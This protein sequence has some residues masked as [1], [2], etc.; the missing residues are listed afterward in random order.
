VL[1]PADAQ[2]AD[3]V[4]GLHRGRLLRCVALVQPGAPV[5]GPVLAANASL[6]EA[7]RAML[8]AGCSQAN[9]QAVDGQH[10]GTL[11]MAAVVAQLAT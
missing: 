3:F 5:P 4:R 8:A 1:Q 10:L 7:A 2:V 6:A 11:A 9:V